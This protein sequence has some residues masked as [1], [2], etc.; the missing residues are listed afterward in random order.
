MDIFIS[1]WYRKSNGHEL[2]T[3]NCRSISV[4]LETQFM[5]KIKKDLSK[6]HLKQQFNNTF[7]YLD[8]IFAFFFF[9]GTGTPLIILE[10]LYNYEL[11]R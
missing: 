7:R 3:T 4:F 1:P 5:S 11:G 8:D 2:C 9:F 10:Y 6:Q